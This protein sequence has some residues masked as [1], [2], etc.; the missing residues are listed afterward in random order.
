MWDQQRGVPGVGDYR[1]RADTVYAIELAATVDV[2]EWGGTKVKMQLE[3]DAWFDGQT[4]RY[5]DGRQTALHLIA[6]E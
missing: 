2:P 5:L 6:A 3:E 4:V 1:L